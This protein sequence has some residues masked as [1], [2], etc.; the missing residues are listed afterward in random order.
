MNE[1]LEI[2]HLNFDENVTEFGQSERMKEYLERA[3]MYEIDNLR[4]SI[5][6]LY[7]VGL[8]KEKTFIKLL[9]KLQKYADQF[10][11]TFANPDHPILKTKWD[12]NYKT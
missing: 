7:Q 6:S 11:I 8:I 1:E 9:V 3:K 2:I 10:G 5:I 4:T 12:K